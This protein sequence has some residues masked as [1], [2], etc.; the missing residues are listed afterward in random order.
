[1][2]QALSTVARRPRDVVARFGGEEFALLLPDTDAASAMK[3]AE[4]CRQAIARLAIPHGKS[5]IGAVVTASIGLGTVTACNQ[6]EIRDL[7]QAVDEQ[8]YA[9]KAGGRDMISAVVIP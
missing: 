3:L 8:L 4:G 1:M 9:A 7:L 2:A 5:S 6:L